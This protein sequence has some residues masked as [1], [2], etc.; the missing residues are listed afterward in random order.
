MRNFIR[1]NV[2]TGLIKTAYMS[3]S[4]QLQTVQ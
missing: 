2:K 3:S 1:E 4:N